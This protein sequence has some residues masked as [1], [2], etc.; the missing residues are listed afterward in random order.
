[1]RFEDLR[2][3]G[4]ASGFRIGEVSW[5]SAYLS[6]YYIAARLQ[7]AYDESGESGLRTEDAGGAQGGSGEAENTAIC[8]DGGEAENDPRSDL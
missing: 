3:Q 4:A 2:Q 8:R 7:G 5:C 6:T 1:M